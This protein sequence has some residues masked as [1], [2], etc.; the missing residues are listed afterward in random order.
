[1]RSTA[2]NPHKSVVMI[3]AYTFLICVTTGVKAVSGT[4][5]EAFAATSVRMLRI[6]PLYN[7]CD[8]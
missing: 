2:L 7:A 6:S 8:F 1:M 4:S 5:K 3:V